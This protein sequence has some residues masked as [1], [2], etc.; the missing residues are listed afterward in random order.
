MSAS[1]TDIKKRSFFRTSS[2]I[3]MNEVCA[4]A[5]CQGFGGS[6]DVTRRDLS[7]RRA[8]GGAHSPPPGTSRAREPPTMSVMALNTCKF[9]ARGSAAASASLRA[10]TSGF[11]GGRA[12]SWTAAPGRARGFR[13]APVTSMALKTGIVGLPNVGKSTLFNAL[14]EN[15][16]A[17][18][19]RASALPR[20]PPSLRRPAR[21]DVPIVARR[22]A[23]RE[24]PLL[25]LVPSPPPH[26]S[27]AG[28]Q[29]PLLHHRA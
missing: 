5:G 18:V 26:A 20:R 3:P 12:L 1:T 17:E 27:R 23:S 4:G 19:R 8:I 15:S 28:G 14:V 29:L 7:G 9:V 11:A 10:R 24:R 13:S 22:V 21:R 2:R 6:G 25:T 16:T